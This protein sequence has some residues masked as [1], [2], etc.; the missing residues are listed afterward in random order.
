MF[1]L[2]YIYKF[3]LCTVVA[4]AIEFMYFLNEHMNYCYKIKNVINTLAMQSNHRID[5]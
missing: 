5:N 4:I 3:Y 2:Y 1:I